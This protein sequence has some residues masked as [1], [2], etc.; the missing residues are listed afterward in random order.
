MG[1]H[2]L[3]QGAVSAV[4]CLYAFCPPPTQPHPVS[5]QAS[6]ARG[7]H[8]H[9]RPVPWRVRVAAGTSRGVTAVLHAL[10]TCGPFGSAGMTR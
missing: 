8:V 3:I 9:A 7:C 10:G 4:R 5:P 1:S 2:E 6:G